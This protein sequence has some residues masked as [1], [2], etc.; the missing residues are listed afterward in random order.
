MV[1]LDILLVTES[2]L[3]NFFPSAQFY[4]HEYSTPYH[5]GRISNGGGILLFIRE[6]ILFKIFED[7]DLEI[8]LKAMFIEINIR[9]S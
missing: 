1:T 6:D 4:I 2:K 5:F 7:V 9:K 8:C 3:D